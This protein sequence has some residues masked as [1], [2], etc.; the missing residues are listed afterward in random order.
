VQVARRDALE[1]QRIERMLA[2][3]PLR[4]LVADAD[5]LVAV[6]RVEDRIDVGLELVEDRKGTDTLVSELAAAT[7]SH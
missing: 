6:V 2:D 7:A 3:E 4:D 5:H 1:A